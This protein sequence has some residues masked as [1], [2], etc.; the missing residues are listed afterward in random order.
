[1]SAESD[2]DRE[3]VESPKKL[4]DEVELATQ[5]LREQA[6]KLTAITN[7]PGR[8]GHPEENAAQSADDAES[9]AAHG[10]REPGT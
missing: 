4:V 9:S 2:H 3:V 8:L 6:W 10:G 5:R 7:L 1:M